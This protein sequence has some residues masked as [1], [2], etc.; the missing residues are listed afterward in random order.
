M[1]FYQKITIEETCF[2][3]IWQLTES[4]EALLEQIN[5]KVLQFYPEKWAAL[6]HPQKKTA[7]VGG[8]VLITTIISKL[9]E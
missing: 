6:Q 7:M 5:F 1:P 9:G 3:A 4:V 8:F 2:V